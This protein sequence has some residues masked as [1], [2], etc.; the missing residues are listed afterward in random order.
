MSDISAIGTTERAHEIFFPQD[1][2][3]ETQ[4]LL[5]GWMRRQPNYSNLDAPTQASYLKRHE[6]QGAELKPMRSAFGDSLVIIGAHPTWRAAQIELLLDIRLY[7]SRVETHHTVAKVQYFAE[8]SERDAL[9]DPYRRSQ[10]AGRVF[11]AEDESADKEVVSVDQISCHFAMTPDVCSGA[12]PRGHVHVLPLL[13]VR[14]GGSLVV[15]V[16]WLTKSTKG[17]IW[18]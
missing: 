8:L 2:D 5:G 10:S 11:Y 4:D 16:P 3:R 18:G 15:A 14:Y 1:I 13:R 17:V 7:P 9:H 12:I 6:Y